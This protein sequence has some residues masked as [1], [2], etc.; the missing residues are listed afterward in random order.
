MD[1]VWVALLI[2][3]VLGGCAPSTTG[4]EE[5]KKPNILLIVLD[6]L[7]YTDLG[8][9]G[10]E[11][12][13]PNLDR[14]ALE[15]VRFTNFHAGPSCAPTRAMLLTGTDNHLAGMGSQQG[16]ETEL[17]SRSPAYQNQLLGHVPTVAEHLAGLGY[18]NIASAKW[19]LGD[20]ADSLPNKR[21]FHQSFV[22]MQGG[23]GHFDDTP[24]FERYKIADWR[25]NDEPVKLPEDFYST[26]YM[27]DKILQYL[28]AKSAG[29]P[30]FAYLGYTAP[31]W[32]LQAPADSIA[33]YAQT[34][35]DGWDVLRGQR[36]QGAKAAGVVDAMTPGVD[37]EPGMQS[38]NALSGHEQ[39]LQ[40]KRM[41]VYAAMVDRVD[42]NI[43]RV[44]RH[45]HESGELANTVIFFMAD[46]GVEGHNMELAGGNDVWVPANFDN[47]LD[48]IGTRNSYVAM[49][50]SWGRA[51]AVPFRDS[52]SKMSEGGIRVPAFV[53]MNGIDAA[54]DTAYMRVMDLAP[55]FIELAG[56]EVPQEMMGRSLLNRWQGG[57]QPYADNEVIAAETYGRRMALRGA[58][59]V[60]LQEAPF[61][62]G[63]WQLYNL[64][65]DA[66]EQEDLSDE[67]PGIRAE[68]I[69]AWERYAE[70]VG[71]INP[72][73]PIYY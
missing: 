39:A 65:E 61:G 41:Q 21:G 1:N 3:L 60:L 12:R 9:F 53:S 46:N 72:E 52:K 31:H 17:Q 23:A 34:Y 19:H 20:T 27:T 26:D 49:G 30:F 25:E 64:S 14:L 36:L 37:H 13:T 55:T 8:A 71:V 2:G 24:L 73:Q 56:G 22:L 45:L 57:A 15:G 11:I 4:P 69:A 70:D 33:K 42:V 63:E 58:W 47:S 38:W 66:G 35:H 62:T 51:S 59:K 40:T 7:G 67:F 28:D 68:L 43:R 18:Y 29:Q 16:L 6:D 44:L 32:P 10:G 5:A 50:A 48:A 54:I